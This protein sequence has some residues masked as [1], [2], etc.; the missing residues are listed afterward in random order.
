M[1][2]A[3]P[4][5]FTFRKRRA[6]GGLLA[7]VMG[8]A[9]L[10][11]LWRTINFNEA[12]VQP[13]ELYR[14]AQMDTSQLKAE[15]KKRG[16]KTVINLRGENAGADWYRQE[17]AAC[18]RLNVHHV[19]VRFSA[20]HLPAPSE[21]TGLIEAFRAA[22]RPLLLHCR[23]GSDRT[24]LAA[25]I[26]LLDQEKVSARKAEAA[27]SL[28]YGHFAIYPYFEMNEF[29]QLYGNSKK[30]FRDWV[31]SDYPSIYIEEGKETRWEEM[32]EPWQSLFTGSS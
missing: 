27:L 3:S 2:V 29:V 6:F 26:Y 28:R 21:V 13:A 30:P 16:I 25:A 10:F 18:D 7:G 23:S 14:S 31:R 32:W 17:V 8:V 1:E 4:F 20:G 15:V 5:D 24:G 11:A 22:P 19:D 12:V 9:G